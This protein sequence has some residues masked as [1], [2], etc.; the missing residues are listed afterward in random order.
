MKTGFRGTFVISWSQTEIDGLTGAPIGAMAVGATWN[1]SGHAV[2]VDD[3]RDI[4][5][6]ER[7]GADVDLHSRAAEQVRRLLGNP[8][9]FEQQSEDPDPALTLFGSGFCLTD[10][11]KSYEATIIES[12]ETT[13][14]MLLFVGAMPP[15]GCDLWVLEMNTQKVAVHGAEQS[16]GVICFVPGTLIATSDGPKLVQDLCQGDTVSTKDSGDQEIQWIGRRRISGARLAAMPQFRP[17]RIKANFFGARQPAP[18]LIVSP[19]HRILLKG[20][21]AQV[22][23]NTPEVLVCARDLI[24]DQTVRVENNMREL[25]YIHLMLKEHQV[26]WANGVECDSF[27][28]ANASLEHLDSAQRWA[29]NQVAPTISDD[30]FSYGDFARRNL[31]QAEAAIL[32]YRH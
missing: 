23:F 1:W 7:S 12:P 8:D 18:D 20:R 10:G 17:V 27:H 32:A 15:A 4:L 28:P 29:L 24:N 11:L 3:P 31:T 30:P 26:I 16:G 21:S 19:G 22:L 14:P 6:L 2:R 25:C 13:E 9:I 5:V